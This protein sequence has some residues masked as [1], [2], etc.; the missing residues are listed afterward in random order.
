MWTTSTAD[1]GV[2]RILLVPVHWPWADRQDQRGSMIL[3]CDHWRGD[4][5]G[6][7]GNPELARP[8]TRHVR[9][10]LARSVAGRGAQEAAPRAGVPAGL[11]LP[12]GPHPQQ[13]PRP[14][15]LPIGSLHVCFRVRGRPVVPATEARSVLAPSSLQPAE[16][17][18]LGE[19]Q[20]RETLSYT[21]PSS[22]CV[23]SRPLG[24]GAFTWSRWTRSQPQHPHWGGEI[25]T[26]RRPGIKRGPPSL[27]LVS[28]S[29]DL[30]PLRCQSNGRGSCQFT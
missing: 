18:S 12:P 14:R 30:F 21:S 3:G 15:R 22:E 24:K 6:G 7:P 16:L 27:S 23:S 19:S 17:A 4:A 8:C 13:L 1:P 26:A 20:S 5:A 28:V 25:P 29:S 11:G 9:P 10:Y 2:P